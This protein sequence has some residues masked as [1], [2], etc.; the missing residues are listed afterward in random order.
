M[1]PRLAG[2]L[3]LAA[4]AMFACSNGG[5]SNGQN[6]YP[7]GAGGGNGNYGNGG[8]N[9]GA[10]SGG[11]SAG[12]TTGGGTTGGGTTGASTTTGTGTTSSAGGSSGGGTTGANPNQLIGPLAF[13]VASAAEF[14][15][16]ASTDGGPAQIEFDMSSFVIDCSGNDAGGNLPD[17]LTL[18]LDLF[19]GDPNTPVQS[20]PTYVF[21]PPDG[22]IPYA[23]ARIV[24]TDGDG[25]STVVAT[26]T[27][28]PVTWSAGFTGIAS[29]TLVLTMSSSS[30]PSNLSGTFV[31]PFCGSF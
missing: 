7:G 6:P 13:T 17:G 2:V 8:A 23:T 12:T 14:L 28:G 26:G 3:A 5:Y 20:G 22:G 16:V 25:G 30:G 31:A 24:R 27:S 18:V 19:S 9:G 10:T 4:A 15:P 11:S 29:G 21:A 1:D